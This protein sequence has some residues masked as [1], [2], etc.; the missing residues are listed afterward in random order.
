MV[1]RLTG[2]A[3]WFYL[4]FLGSTMKTGVLSVEN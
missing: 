1:Q 4:I 3:D 2:Y